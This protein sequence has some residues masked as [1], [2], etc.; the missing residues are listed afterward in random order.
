M[1]PGFHHVQQRILLFRS[2]VRAVPG[3]S[4]TSSALYTQM[5]TK[6]K[7]WPPLCED[8]EALVPQNRQVST[9][10]SR[11]L[12]RVRQSDEVED[13]AVDDFVRQSVLLVKQD[14]DEQGDRA[15][16]AR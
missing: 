4:K 5:T 12:V 2:Q 10:G 15:C 3:R 6:L 14:P 16:E 13:H 1:R 11:P 8:E 9:R 7:N